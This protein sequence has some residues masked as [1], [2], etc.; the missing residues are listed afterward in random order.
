MIARSAGVVDF[1]DPKVGQAD[2]IGVGRGFA[3]PPDGVTVAGLLKEPVAVGF[4]VPVTVY[5]IVLPTG[6][7]C[8]FG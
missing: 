8:R 6:K 5:V 1:G 3:L 2:T 4:T 7:S